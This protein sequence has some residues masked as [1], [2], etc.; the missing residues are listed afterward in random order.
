M[1]VC[2][3]H[4]NRARSG[5][6]RRASWHREGKDDTQEY[7]TTAQE[8]RS[9][10]LTVQGQGKGLL[11]NRGLHGTEDCWTDPHSRL[12]WATQALRSPTPTQGMP[13]WPQQSQR[14][15]LENGTVNDMR[16]KHAQCYVPNS[17]VF[18]DHEGHALHVPALHSLLEEWKCPVPLLCNKGS[19]RSHSPTQQKHGWYDWGIEL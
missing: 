6:R 14:N 19:H 10:V 7:G 16:H 13:P 1:H 2:L 18:L 12:K 17:A 3:W 5:T 4:A 15:S 11:P 9:S 8:R